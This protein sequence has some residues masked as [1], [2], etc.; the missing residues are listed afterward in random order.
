FQFKTNDGT[1]DS[2]LGTVSIT[3][4]HVNH[5]PVANDDTYNTNEETDLSVSAPGVK[6]NDTD[7]D[8][9]T[10]TASLVNGPSNAQSFTLHADGSFD[11]MPNPGYSGVDQFTYKVNVGTVDSNT[12]T[13]YLNVSHV[14]HAPTAAGDSYSTDE[15]TQLVVPAAGVLT[16]DSDLDG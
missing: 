2:A 3:V 16:N 7:E 14:N 6:Q 10:L 15:D 9:D 4:N 8:G 5:A 12:A 1:Q 13:V 11:Y